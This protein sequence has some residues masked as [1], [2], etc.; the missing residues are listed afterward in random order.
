MAAK[1]PF[2]HRQIPS[3]VVFVVV[4]LVYIVANDTALPFTGT[5]LNAISYKTKARIHHQRWTPSVLDDSGTS[6]TRGQTPSSASTPTNKN[7]RKYSMF[8]A[9]DD[10]KELV[11]E[12]LGPDAL[13]DFFKR[14][15]RV[16]DNSSYF[17]WSYSSWWRGN[18][19]SYYCVWSKCFWNLGCDPR[20]K[21]RRWAE[22]ALHVLLVERVARYDR[23][24]DRNNGNWTSSIRWYDIHTSTNR[25]ENFF[26]KP[27][28]TI[29]G[30]S[31]LFLH[32]EKS[33]LHIISHLLLDLGA[34]PVG[35]T[36]IRLGTTILHMTHWLY[37]GVHTQHTMISMWLPSSWEA[38][39]VT[40]GLQTKMDGR[41]ALHHLVWNETLLTI[42]NPW[43]SWDI[44]ISYVDERRENRLY[45]HHGWLPAVELLGAMTIRLML[46]L[47]SCCFDRCL[48]MGF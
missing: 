21:K 13:G 10:R 28:R 5:V 24:D 26:C 43:T 3:S 46:R 1:I 14:Y 19:L 7:K 40:Q 18:P 35:G 36:M 34:C 37:S 20:T 47:H 8:N 15:T 42:R 11:D 23:T 9:T 29:S 2:S 45:K 12:L 39:C 6:A 41:T 16:K 48:R 27:W 4:P 31:A 38:G 22:T 44:L 17:I 33:V 25:R 30:K 32:A